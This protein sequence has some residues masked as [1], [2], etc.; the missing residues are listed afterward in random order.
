MFDRFEKRMGSGHKPSS[1]KHGLTLIELLVVI[2]L[3]AILIAFFLPAV[4]TS[5]PLA[6]RSACKNNLKQIALALHN[7]ADVYGEF[8]PA[9]TVDENGGPLHSW[10]TLIL[11]YLEQEHLYKQIDLTKPWDDP[12]NAAAYNTSLSIYHCLEDDSPPTHTTYLAIV[13]SDSFFQ[14]T[15]GRKLS[16]GIGEKLLVIEVASRHAVHWMA[17]TDADEELVLGFGLG[18][19]LPHANGVNAA[20]ADGSVRFLQADLPAE[21]RR[22]LISVNGK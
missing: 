18:T 2:S 5:R 14:S 12:A 9:Y 8:P 17:P 22:K 20:F 7:Y 21:E 10:R 19:A 16:N 1:R 11:P 4:R 6:R 15:K 3:I 13:T